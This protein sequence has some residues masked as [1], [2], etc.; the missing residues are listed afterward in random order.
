MLWTELHF[1]NLNCFICRSFIILTYTRIYKSVVQVLKILFVFVVH[2]NQSIYYASYNSTAVLDNQ[3]IYGKQLQPFSRE[4]INSVTKEIKTERERRNLSGVSGWG[5]R[6]PIMIPTL[7]HKSNF[8]LEIINTF[9]SEAHPN[10]QSLISFHLHRY[11]NKTWKI[12]I[13]FS[14]SRRAYV[15]C[16]V[17]LNDSNA[18]VRFLKLSS[19]LGWNENNTDTS[20]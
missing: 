7:L 17:V 20:F 8:L 9:N 16:S 14:A 6:S 19:T 1:D 10:C 5:R 15:S 12:I 11:K 4:Y 3:Q 18:P 2:G 13:T